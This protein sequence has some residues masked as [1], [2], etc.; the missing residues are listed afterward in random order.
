MMCAAFLFGNHFFRHASVTY[1]AVVSVI[2]IFDMNSELPGSNPGEV[3][4]F[5]FF[6]YKLFF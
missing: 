3:F 2:A 4:S 1:G 6:C 5:F